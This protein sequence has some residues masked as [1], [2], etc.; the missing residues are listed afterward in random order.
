VRL[1]GNDDFA[2]ERLVAY[3][4]GYRWQ[5][6]QRLSLD[7]ALFYNDYDRLASL[8]IGTPFIAPD[9]RTVVPIVN[10]NLTAGHTRGAELLVEWSPSDIWQ[11]TAN[12]THLEMSLTPSGTDLNRGEWLEG[13]TPRN[14]GGLRSL[15]TLGER[16]E[17][18]AQY[19][20]QSRISLM[21]VAVTRAAIDGYSELDVRLGWRVSDH[22]ELALVGQNLLHDEHVEFG[23][24]VARG[25]LER[26]GYLKAAWRN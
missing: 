10:R 19:R 16:F 11:L 6:R 23:P 5:A 17:I 22:W 1:L 9:G 13:S 3:E 7:L 20:R 12:Y 2:A 26:A 14:I 18:D 21:P 4:A 8:E 24:A 15:L 25:S